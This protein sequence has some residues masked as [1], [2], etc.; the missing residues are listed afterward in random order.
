MAARTETYIL[1]L[2]RS[3]TT[4]L[5][6]NFTYLMQ[7]YTEASVLRDMSHNRSI[8]LALGFDSRTQSNK[9]RYIYSVAGKSWWNKWQIRRVR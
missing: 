8:F 4:T 9:T 6:N 1:I 3:L 2:R 5:L 7:N